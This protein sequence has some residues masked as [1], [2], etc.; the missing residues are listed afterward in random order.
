MHSLVGRTAI[1]TGASSGIGEAVARRFSAAGASVVITARRADR[2]SALADEL[3]GAGGSVAAIAADVTREE[4]V[5]RL[6]GEAVRRHGRL[7]ILVN[8]AGVADSTPIEDLSLERWREVMDS[9]LVSAFL[10]CRAAFGLMKSQGQGRIIVVGSISALTPRPR[11]PAYTASKFA[12]EGLTRSLA[13]DGR[14]HGVTVGIVHPGSTATELAPGLA[15][16]NPNRTMRPDA[17]AE[18]VHCVA[19]MPNAVN[20]L[21]SVVLP[22]AQPFLGRG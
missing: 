11:S 5:E 7:D 21:H 9:N 17:V 15:S 4:Q 19:A 18:I 10:C 8:N 20:V 22:I 2:L 1:V 6:F 13:L 3:N 14:E 16:A 12:L